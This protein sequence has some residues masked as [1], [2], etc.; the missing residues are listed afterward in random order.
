MTSNE[1]IDG[2]ENAPAALT[3][4][5]A[6]DTLVSPQPRKLST[7]AQ[8]SGE[9]V[10]SPEF[11]GGDT[12][13][14][15]RT[16]NRHNR[17][18]KTIKIPIPTEPPNFKYI[19]RLLGPRGSSIRELEQVTKCRI[20]IKGRGSMR[21]P[22]KEDLYRNRPGYE[23]LNED[24]HVRVTVFDNDEAQEKLSMAQRIVESLLVATNDVY[25]QRQLVQLSLM[26]GTYRPD[27]SILKHEASKADMGSSHE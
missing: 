27:Y 22:A 16:P 23:H 12:L 8:S 9:A 15:S 24:L 13:S 14:N 2:T 10:S 5:G 21:D 11:A 26:N 1:R 25:K 4:S 18:M 20:V 6:G 19:G 17:R 3:I 7:E